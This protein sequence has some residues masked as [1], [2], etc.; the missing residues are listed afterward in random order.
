MDDAT[1]RQ[2][3]DEHAAAVHRGDFDAVAA[4]F[5]PEMQAALPEIA[6]ALPNPVESAEVLSTEV[7]DDE[8]VAQIRYSGTDGSAVTIRS[9]WRQVDGR[10]LIFQGEP[11]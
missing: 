6:K 11:I 2:V 1:F 5:V 4:D 8:S 10:P 3:A 9:H 7:G